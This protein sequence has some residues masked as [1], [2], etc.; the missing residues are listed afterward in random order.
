MSPEWYGWAAYLPNSFYEK[1]PQFVFPEWT[2]LPKIIELRARYE[3]SCL[4]YCIHPN[5]SVLTLVSLH[6]KMCNIIH[7]K[8]LREE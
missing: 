7:N 4:K 6:I 5:H 2:D 8:M 1:L 3:H